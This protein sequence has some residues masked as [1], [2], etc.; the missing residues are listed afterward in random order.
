MNKQTNHGGFVMHHLLWQQSGSNLSPCWLRCISKKEESTQG[1][2]LGFQRGGVCLHWYK[3]SSSAEQHVVLNVE[4]CILCLTLCSY[5]I[6]TQLKPRLLPIGK[7]LPQDDS[8]TP[9]ITFR[10]ELP[11][12]DAL[13]RHPADREHGVSSNLRRAQKQIFFSD[14]CHTCTWM[15]FFC[16]WRHQNCSRERRL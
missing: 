2:T 8:E 15:Y 1:G 9:D 11:V 16:K 6:V 5:L 14:T 4:V 12:H 3:D 13:W 10:G 7:D